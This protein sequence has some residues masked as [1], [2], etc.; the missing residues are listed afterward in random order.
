MT[1]IDGPSSCHVTEPNVRGIGTV[2]FPRL[3]PPNA[4]CAQNLAQRTLTTHHNQMSAGLVQTHKRLD[5]EVFAAYGWPPHLE[6]N[7]VVSN[8]LALNKERAT[9]ST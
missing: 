4:K 7:N 1:F 5:A 6:N 8:V 9:L 3:V 2:R